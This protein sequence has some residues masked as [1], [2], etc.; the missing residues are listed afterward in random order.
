MRVVYL[1][2]LSA[3][4]QSFTRVVGVRVKQK[5]LGMA[6]GEAGN[7]GPVLRVRQILKGVA[8]RMPVE[9]RTK[10]RGKTPHNLVRRHL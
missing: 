7:G 3:S 4:L 6:H 2:I 9:A 10:S 5:A 8:Y 1:P